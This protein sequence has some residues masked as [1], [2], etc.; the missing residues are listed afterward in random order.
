M[1]YSNKGLIEELNG[2]FPILKRISAAT[3]ESVLKSEV[4]LDLVTHFL[5]GHPFLLL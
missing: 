4:L 1:E 2:H 3:N 5:S